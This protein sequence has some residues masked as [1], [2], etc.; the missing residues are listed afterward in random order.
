MIA[1]CYP[2]G[3]SERNRWLASFATA[4]VLVGGGGLALGSCRSDAP[5]GDDLLEV[6][7]LRP[8]DDPARQ[9]DDAVWSN[10]GCTRT[11]CHDHVEPIR[12]PGSEMMQRIRDRG[13]AF[14]DPDG[15]IVCHGGSLEAVAAADAH[16][17]AVPALADEGGPDAFFADPASPWVNARSCGQCHAE[18]V[19]AQH[20]SL[21]MTEAGKIQGTTWSFG[22]PAGDS[23]DHVWANYAARNPNDPDARLGTAAY[24]EY[25][26]D[27]AAA[28]PNVFVDEH[29]AIPAAPEAHTL[30][31]P[32]AAAFTYIRAEC[33]R[34]HLG[35]K[36]R[37]RR[38]DFRGMGCGACHMPYGNEGVYEGDDLS[39]GPHPGGRPLVHRI[40]ATRDAPVS[41]HGERYTGIPVET[42]TT[43]H[44]RGKRIGVSYQGLMEAAWDSPY[45]EGGGGQLDLHSKHYLSMEE[46][47]H[48][49]AGMLCQDCHTS[50]DVHGDGFLSGSNLGMV[51]IECSDCHG[52]PTHYPWELP[53]GWGDE[54]E[55]GEAVGPP[56]GVATEVPRHLMA[57]LVQDVRDGYL[58]STRG[59]PMPEIVRVDDR[60]VVHTAGGKDLV[61]EPLK[62]KV[63]HETLSRE[64]TV[65]M[66]HEAKHVQTMEC[67][68]CHASWAPQCYG[69]HVKVDYS[70]FKRSFDW[71]AA[72]QQHEQAEH[73]TDASELG[74]DT[75]LDGEVTEMRSYMRWED[76][77][78]GVNGEGRVSPI[79]PGC[80]VSV[81]VIGPDGEELVRNEL[82]RTPPHTEGGGAQGQIGSDMSPLQPHTIGKARSCESCHG[83]RKAMGFGIGGTRAWDEARVV[84]LT[85][86]DGRVLP[87]SARP[88]FEAIEGLLADWS[89]VLDPDGTQT[90][91]VG[92][93]FRGSGPLTEAQRAKMDRRQVCIAC[94]EEIPET[95]LAVSV[96]HHIAAATGQLDMTREEHETLLHRILLTT[97]WF[98][99]LGALGAGVIFIGGT[100]WVIR[101]RRRRRATEA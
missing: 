87:H 22:T 45:T 38:G 84:D 17:G 59:N 72:G 35:V 53:L 85:T 68:S 18:L 39:L 52:T 40:Q 75:W 44:N 62:R 74:Y 29:E 31:D 93:H 16:H 48:Y 15:C 37:P 60:V 33:Q 90:Q 13:D 24:R 8:I 89:A 81:T 32:R 65:A 64:A 66:V 71:V 78:L 54:N 41:V 5:A 10:T 83:S 9:V 49:R 101:R 79:V 51:E 11:G 76:P 94:H 1:G 34:C 56:R 92:H 80:Q 67:Y 70:D 6:S 61:L 46:D 3:V 20:N 57:G 43:C 91:T 23:Y 14:G 63:E 97:A 99:V 69:C 27:K 100:L 7:S 2:P 42:C 86:A 21:M 88:Q 95:S 19:S 30:D 77:A 58:L 12:D 28:H 4:F 50:G 47:V 82:F 25:M 36:G 96:L 73:R 98:E 26:A 55:P